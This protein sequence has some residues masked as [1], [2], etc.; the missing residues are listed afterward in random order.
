MAVFYLTISQAMDTALTPANLPP[1]VGF[2]TIKEFRKADINPTFTNDSHI[3]TELYRLGEKC[4]EMS[5]VECE[6]CVRLRRNLCLRSMVAQFAPKNHILLAHMGI[7]R[8][9]LQLTL[10]IEGAPHKTLCFAKLAGG[11]GSTLT[12]RN[13]NG[14]TLLS[15]IVS[16]VAKTDFS[17]VAKILE[18][19][20]GPCA[21]L[22]RNPSYTFDSKS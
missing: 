10:T 22:T 8:S 15:Q 21:G 19:G 14:S 6:Q 4:T 20:L 2:S 18:K 9:D 12:L 5:D 7:E 16:Q 11:K 3:R 17:I 13:K 1:V